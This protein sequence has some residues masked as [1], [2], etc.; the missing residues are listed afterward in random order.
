MK[1]ILLVAFVLVTAFALADGQVSVNPNV[2]ASNY[3]GQ[4]VGSIQYLPPI[5]VPEPKPIPWPWPGPVCLSCPPF[6]LDR[7]DKEVLP[8]DQLQI[9]EIQIQETQI[10]E[11][12]FVR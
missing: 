1:K 7:L 11:R 8:V 9:Q 4:Q 6:P 2:A 3:V 12:N 5:P 10:Q